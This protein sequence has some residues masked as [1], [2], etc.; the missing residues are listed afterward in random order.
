M[1]AFQRF[2]KKLSSIKSWL[3]NYKVRIILILLLYPNI[4]CYTPD[5][6]GTSSTVIDFLL[7]IGKYAN[8]TYN[9]EG[10]ATSVTKYSF[11]DYGGSV[12]HSIDEF[13][14]GVRGGGY[15]VKN[16]GREDTHNN[17][18]FG[19][20]APYTTNDNSTQYINPFIGF[21]NKYIAVNFGAVFLSEGKNW[22]VS[23]IFFN[24]GPVQPSWLLR[25]GNKEKVHFSTQYLS[26]VPLLSGGGMADAGLGFGST[27]TRNL[28][29]VGLSFGPFQNLGLSVKQN[30]Q[31]TD[32]VDI[33]IRGRIG[34][35]ESNFEGGISAGVSFIL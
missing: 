4:V 29:W 17:Y 10:Q 6:T 26:N 19:D 20:Y 16:L 23:E 14:F 28:T 18:L 32:N 8:V 33:L 2:E 34:T 22:N 3:L 24:D 13:K 27:E 21:E 5:S 30:I 12:N 11:F 15:S 9:C 31:V 35:I 7:G 25:I 1:K